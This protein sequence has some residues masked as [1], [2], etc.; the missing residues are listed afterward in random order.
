[1][2]NKLRYVFTNI[3]VTCRKSRSS[4]INFDINIEKLAFN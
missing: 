3:P 2:Q 4:G 1:M